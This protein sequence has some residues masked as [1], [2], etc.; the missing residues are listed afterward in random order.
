MKALLLDSLDTPS[1]GLRLAADSAWRPDRRPLFAP[2]GAAG[3]T[4]EPRVAI[5]VGRLGKCIAPRHAV[6]YI[7]AWALSMVRADI[8]G[9]FL[10]ADDAI[11]L[12]PWQ[13]LDSLHA[14]ITLDSRP[15][16]ATPALADIAAALSTLSD[17]VT[18]KTGDI[19]LL[20]PADTSH[21][22]T[23]PYSIHAGSDG[24]APLISF[25]IR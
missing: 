20:P 6:R 17:G 23:A 14:S 21:T 10:L 19:L 24:T 9:P 7:D 25:N 11:V 22:Y 13:Q 8:T 5:R 16:G 18:F 12:G 1:R 3:V 15:I 4:L 2:E